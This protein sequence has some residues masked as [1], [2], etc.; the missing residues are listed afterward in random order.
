MLY[1]WPEAEIETI[2]LVDLGGARSDPEG[3]R[4]Q[5]VALHARTI[6]NCFVAAVVIASAIVARTHIW[7]TTI[8]YDEAITLLTTSG[9]A[10]TDW[11]LGMQQ[12]KPTANL[13]TILLQLYGQDVHP[14]LYFW[15][16]AIWRVLFGASLEVARW[17]S[18]LFALAT[19]GLLYRY[20]IEIRMRWSSLPVIIYAVS[21]VGLRYAYNARPY[22]MATF[23]IVLTLFLAH[24]KS[25]WT[26]V[27]A[28]A[29]V[30]T[31]YFAALCVGPIIAIECF[32]GWKTDR[33]WTSW[34]AISFAAFCGPLT[35]L[36]ANHVGARPHQFPGFGI[37]HKEVHALLKGA[38][39]GA[40]PYTPLWRHSNLAL[41]LAALLPAA[42]GIWAIRRKLLTL[43]FTYAAFLCGFL[44][45]AIATHKSVEK[46]PNAYYLGIGAPLL[47]L[48][49][50]YGVN[51]VP[52]SS[53]LLAFALVVGTVTATPL[54]PTIDYRAM[55]GHIRSEC[56]HCVVL[57]GFGYGG[58]V[59]ACV[60]YEAKG[61]DVLLLRASDT[62]DEIV[63]RIGTG[64]TIF[65]ISSNDPPTAQVEGEFVQA[66]P[67]VPG[68]GYFRIDPT[69]RNPR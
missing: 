60:L 9:H 49:I 30:A 35:I 44:I 25:K 18:T 20:A 55:L 67:S 38:V 26:G 33:R 36:V 3:S 27:C 7:S 5:K 58:A 8:W 45:L 13:I 63:Q 2:G 47:V 16:L 24:R 34:T 46:M 22:A 10:T 15:T 57:V 53:P 1:E 42:G 39:E 48:L 66:Y 43:S 29:C 32:M 31:H 59:P 62:P 23:L 41:L 69:F 19:L 61:L 65:L 17:L 64:R 14:P 12:F 40:T 21:A 37:F 11:S 28:A 68:D 51:A 56:D 54:M 4:S 52:L 6:E 50:A